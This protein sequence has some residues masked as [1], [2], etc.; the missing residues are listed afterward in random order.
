MHTVATAGL[1]DALPAERE[2]LMG[3]AADRGIDIEVIDGS[4][5]ADL[6]A[7]AVIRSLSRVGDD[8]WMV[9]VGG[10][11]TEFVSIVGGQVASVISL[12][13]GGVGLTEG[14][15]TR[16]PPGADLLA[17]AR[18]H[19]ADMVAKVEVPAGRALPVVAAG[20][21]ATTLAAVLHRIEP[22]DADRVHGIR[23]PVTDLS[24]GI[25]MLATKTLAQLLGM[26]GLV[27]GRADI[28]VGGAI[29]LEAAARRLGSGT[30]IVSDRGL[31]WGLAYEIAGYM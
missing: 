24:D 5:E 6:T 25:D 7:L 3:A 29:A 4:R 2:R 31:R 22:Y 28:A 15:L 1:R 9:D 12:E 23:V 26:P 18:T 10:R 14:L 21:T 8:L 30:L 11:S 27:P 17:L 13:L 20:G 16:D 19:A